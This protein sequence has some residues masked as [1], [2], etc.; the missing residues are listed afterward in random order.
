M[1]SFDV[2]LTSTV[3]RGLEEQTLGADDGVLA[4][5]MGIGGDNLG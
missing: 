5:G 4:R 3:D 2:G 1:A